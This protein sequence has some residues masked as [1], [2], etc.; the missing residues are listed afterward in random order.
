M[1]CYYDLNIISFMVHVEKMMNAFRMEH[2]RRV[3]LHR[4]NIAN[5]MQHKRIALFVPCHMNQLLANKS[6][7]PQY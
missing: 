1:Y 2:A 3:N 4:D 7:L 5:V 6:M